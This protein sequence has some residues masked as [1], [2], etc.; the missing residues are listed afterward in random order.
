MLLLS[1]FVLVLAHIQDSN[2]IDILAAIALTTQVIV[3]KR[4]DSVKISFTI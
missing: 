3:S 4:V 2:Q 1:S